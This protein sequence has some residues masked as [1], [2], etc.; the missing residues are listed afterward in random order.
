MPLIAR[1]RL[2]G[3]LSIYRTG[4]GR[5]F[6]DEE[7]ELVTDFAAVAAL[8]LD[9][10]RSRAELELLAQ[11]DDLTGLSNR[12]HFRNELERQ[13]AAAH[14]TGSPLSLL[15]LDLDNFKAINDSHGHERGDAALQAVA[16]AIK[17]Q[18]RP[19]DLAARVG[20]DEFVIMLPHTGR[21]D[22]QALAEAIATSISHALA[23]LGATASVGVSALR[24]RRDHNL[25]AEADRLLYQAK[26]A[27]PTPDSIRLQAPA[28]QPHHHKHMATASPPG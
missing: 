2:L 4:P 7:V 28:N 13:I 12:R 6:S 10:A 8:A 23:P 16:E 21:T 9:N 14:Q 26:R 19:T 17:Q 27:H 3:V 25:L 22:A 1:D 20:G 15:L 11:T 18:L 24:E 5:E